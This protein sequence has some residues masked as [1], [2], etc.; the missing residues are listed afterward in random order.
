[1]F[2]LSDSRSQKSKRGRVSEG[3]SEGG[4][5]AQLVQAKL[6]LALAQQV[7]MLKAATMTVVLIPASSEFVKEASAVVAKYVAETKGKSGQHEL[8]P[9]DFAVFRAVVAVMLTNA[10]GAQLNSLKAIVEPLAS[11]KDLQGKVLV[12][13]LCKCYSSNQKRFE[14]CLKDLGELENLMA[15][16]LASAGGRIQHGIGPRGNLERA[17]RG[18]VDEADE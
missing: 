12:F 9:L 1:M 10:Q 5:K 15:L 6:T 13:R 4:E 14:F 7:R 3:E 17:L 8:G 16:S 18:F 11:P 2:S